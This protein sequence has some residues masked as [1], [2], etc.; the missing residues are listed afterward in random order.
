MYQPPGFGTVFPYFFV[1]NAEAFSSFLIK[2]FNAVE[3]NRTLRPDGKIA[4]LSMKIGDTNFMA[5]E[6]SDD[7]PAT[8]AAYYLYVRNADVSMQQACEH[9]AEKIMSV[10]DMA[11]GDRQGGVRDPFGNIWWI[12]QR[13]VEAPY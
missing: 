6:A 2:A 10:A 9:G 1:N 11:Y 5:S 8:S 13:M 12:S 4:N 7:F 3:L